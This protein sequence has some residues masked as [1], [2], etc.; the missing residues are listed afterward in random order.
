MEDGVGDQLAPVVI[1]PRM[2]LFQTLPGSSIPGL[3]E[4]E[5]TKQH[6]GTGARANPGKRCL[7]EPDG[8]RLS[9]RIRRRLPLRVRFRKS[10]S[11]ILA[12]EAVSVASGRLTG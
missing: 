3:E 6:A 8:R 5:S 10:T 11:R 9:Q 1:A 4:W 2:R 7:V 12:A